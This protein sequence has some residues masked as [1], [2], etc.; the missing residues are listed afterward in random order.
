[1]GDRILPGRGH[2]SVAELSLWLDDVDDEAG[3]LR[4]VEWL[5]ARGARPNGTA[6]CLHRS[7]V[8]DGFASVTDHAR[9]GKPFGSLLDLQRLV[10]DV[11]IVPVSLELVE[12]VTFQSDTAVE[13]VFERTRAASN[14]HPISIIFD[15]HEVFGLPGDPPGR[16]HGGAELLSLLTAIAENSWLS[17]GAIFN[18]YSM[19]AP[20]DLMAAQAAHF[21]DFF[22]ASDYVGEAAVTEISDLAIGA[23]RRSDRGVLVSTS[24]V[25]GGVTIDPVPAATRFVASVQERSAP[26]STPR[27]PHE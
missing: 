16:R 14:H 5:L 24:S 3:L 13:V 11:R 21:H 26:S 18:E 4:V 8:P 27:E 25:L 17:Y 15:D 22:V 10:D 2:G 23:A 12:V 20:T 1:M 7:E 19:P 9:V 6:W